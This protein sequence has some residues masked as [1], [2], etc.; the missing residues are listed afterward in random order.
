MFWQRLFGRFFSPNTHRDAIVLVVD[1]HRADLAYTTCAVIY[2]GYNILKASSG[3]SGLGLALQ[4]K[5]DL[6]IVD[7]ELADMSGYDFC[8]QLKAGTVTQGIPV[9]VLT[10]LN[11]PQAV[12]E[13]YEQGV[14]D[15]LLKPI[16][17]KSLLKEIERV[18]REVSQPLVCG[19]TQEV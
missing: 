10:A 4:H 15:Y 16:G 1:P 14:T 7:F 6:I 8:C 11:T 12:L 18:L 13:A 3:K 5:P 9:I 2:G 19:K 17:K